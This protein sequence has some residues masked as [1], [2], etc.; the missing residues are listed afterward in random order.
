MKIIGIKDLSKK[1]IYRFDKKDLLIVLTVFII[2][3]INN[4]TFINGEGIAPDAVSAS[5]F[6]IA[7]KWELQLGRFLICAI[8]IMRYG[9]ISKILIIIISL[10][11][12]SFSIMLLKRIFEIK[13][14][15]ILFLLSFIICVAP[16][17]TE[18]YM[19]IYCADAYL[20]AFLFSVLTVYC[21]KKINEKKRYIVYS[22]LT[23]IIVCALYQ[24]YLGVILGLVVVLLIRL[25][26]E[27][28]LRKSEFIKKALSWVG[29]LIIGIIAYYIILNIL[30]I[31]FNAE[32][33]SY[34]GANGLGIETI[35][36]LPGG[37]LQSYIDSFRFF[38]KDNI[39]NNTYYGRKI[40]YIILFVMTMIGA[41]KRLLTIKNNKTFVSIAS[42]LLIIVFPVC[43][44]IMNLIA[45]GTVI[46]L[47]TG[48]GI[49]VTILFPILLLDNI[50]EDNLSKILSWVCTIAIIILSWTFLLENTYTYIARNQTY[51]N[52]RAVA[53]DIYNKATSL[54]DYSKD[55]K[56]MFSDIIRFKVNDREKANGFISND[57]AMWN[58]Y[59]GTIQ[60]ISYYEKYLGI[61]IKIVEKN[62]Y[63]TIKSK[64]EFK[65]MPIYPEPGS[66]KII[67][68]V[69]V[70][71]TSD[72][73]Y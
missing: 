24:A 33:V 17:F 69:I 26:F 3:L 44:N 14:R 1:I 43:V 16:Q 46:N 9:L 72:K 13:S 28:E 20:I 36:K 45:S 4:F 57:N 51:A 5:Y 18:T 38:F 42:I 59:Q 11:C 39:I 29:I 30:L 64:D 53:T 6:D 47:V 63:D 2:G 56:W 68:N 60:N 62:E 15:L 67:N 22:I 7:G 49:L 37:I 73:V 41:I 19:F 54:Q 65:E 25:L 8:N 52:Y 66:I 55:K 58:N 61:K 71:K 21:L 10:I 27:K 50:K 32:L 31:I 40:I 48:P 35:L 12:I 34:K 23:T 70:I